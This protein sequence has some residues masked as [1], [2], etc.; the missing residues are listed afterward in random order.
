M[1]FDSDTGILTAG[2]GFAGN[3]SG[4][5]GSCTGNAATATLASSCT[6][7]E[8]NSNNE[9]VY[10]VFVDGAT[11]SQGLESDTGLNYNPNTGY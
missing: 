3:V 1:T 11:G 6:I 9:T 10:P 5:S 7:S 2:G 4:S 8:N